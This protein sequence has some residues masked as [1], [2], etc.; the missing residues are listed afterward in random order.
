MRF[1]LT[2][3]IAMLFTS[4]ATMPAVSSEDK[5]AARKLVAEGTQLH[6]KGRYDEAISKYAE[7]LKIDSENTAALY[8]TAFSYYSKQ[9]YNKSVAFAKKCLEIK[10]D[11][12]PEVYVILGSI[13]DEKG[14][15]DVALAIYAKGISYFPDYYN[16]Y[17]N[18]GIT[19]MNLKKNSE[20][21]EAFKQSL[22]LNPNNASANLAM[23]KLYA[24]SGRKIPAILA[25]SRSLM[26]NS[27]AP[28]AT[29]AFDVL[30]N[31]LNEGVSDSDN[32]A[33]PEKKEITLTLNINKDLKEGDFTEVDLSLM[34][35]KS[36]RQKLKP[37]DKSA[38]QSRSDELDII[39]NSMQG[40]TEKEVPK[41]F[42]WEYYGP[43]FS[44]IQKQGLTETFSYYI[45]QVSG[46]KEVTDWIEK[47]KEKVGWLLEFN[48]NFVWKG[49]SK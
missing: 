38:V 43:Y 31:Q 40:L 4:C 41:G 36:A 12:T 17:F 2:L 44:A 18:R 39:I 8:E 46:E 20:A 14:K 7:A 25:S 33:D 26:L 27:K 35:F 29:A 1:F 45:Q 6:D 19:L 30:V 5:A 15:P 23:A 42:A 28:K 47:N 21:L 13:L 49:K 32:P 11:F 3:I 48:K 24:A 22:L 9:D 10:P 37:A 34:V 16:L